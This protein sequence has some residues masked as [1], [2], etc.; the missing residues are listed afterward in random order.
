MQQL[1]PWPTSPSEAERLQITF[2]PRVIR[3]DQIGDV[4]TVAGVDVAYAKESNRVVAAVAV[5]DAGTLHSIEIVTAEAEAAFPYVSGLFSFREL[6]SVLVAYAKL[7]RR[8]D[9]IV[10]DGHGIAH[11]RR[12]GMACHLGLL[13][14]VPTIG[15]AKTRLIGDHQRPALARGSVAPLLD[16]DEEIGSVLRTQTNVKPVFVS[17]G[18]RV[19]QATANDWALRLSSRYRLPETTRAADHAVKMAL[20]ALPPP[21]T[22]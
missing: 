12:F 16:G 11:P 3:H 22:T 10:C 15:C 18:H 8:P 13:L 19:S 5:L 14:D 6:P 17:V 2:A 20:K 7:R 21:A 4:M 9:L 1:P